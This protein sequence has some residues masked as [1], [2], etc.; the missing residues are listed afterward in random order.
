M[1]Q[2][3]PDYYKT[4]D[5]PRDA[6]ADQ[7]KKAFRKLA[8]EHHPDAGGDEAK[9]KEIN[10]AYEVLS[11][12]KKRNLYDQYGTANA[13]QIPNGW[14][15]GN[16]GDM[17]SGFGSWA[18]I[19]ES[20]RSGEGAFGGFNFNGFGGQRG[21]QQGGCRSSCGSG[22][23][24]HGGPMKGQ[25]MN[26]TLKLSFQEAFE[27]VEKRVTVRIPGKQDPVTL[28][29]KVPAGAVDGGRLRYRGQGAPSTMGGEPGDLLVSFKLDPHPHFERDGA[30]VIV[31][32]PVTVAEAALGASVVVPAPDG[33]KI[34][35][36]VP[37]GTQDGT[38]LTVR[39]K[40]AAKVKGQGNGDLQVKV[41]V[42]V[43][44]QMNDEQKQ[45]MEAYLAAT[46][47][48]VRTWL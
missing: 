12:E 30:D 42:K 2:A 33:T 10:E 35:V 41:L 47:E 4:L 32:T 14:P 21:P 25:D 44:T 27:G 13:N 15:G 43:P 24:G 20:I 6:D 3:T 23:G 28:T 29:V 8:R 5:V 40:G 34:R 22:C 45:A 31:N 7:I 11:D 39:G 26:V 9:F 19:L 17:F 36:K 38:L 48:E 16:M 37:A 46:K 1:A 18:D